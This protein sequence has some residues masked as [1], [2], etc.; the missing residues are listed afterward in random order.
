MVILVKPFQKKILK[1][2]LPP[3]L[4]TSKHPILDLI[5]LPHQF[6][7][8][9][10]PCLYEPS[11]YGHLDHPAGEVIFHAGLTLWVFAHEGVE[12]AIFADAHAV[13]WIFAG[14]EYLRDVDPRLV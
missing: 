7:M 3:I 14:T 4:Q 13:N 2:D 10:I 11:Q 12:F 9:T 1:I 5:D 8:H 6:M